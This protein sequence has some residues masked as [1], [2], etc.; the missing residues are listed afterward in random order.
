MA[1]LSIYSMNSGPVF[2]T[3]STLSDHCYFEKRQLFLRSY[4]FSRKKTFSERINR[5][6]VR[7]KR[8]IWVKLKAARKLRRFVWSELR[9]F[10]CRRRRFHRLTIN[11]RFGACNW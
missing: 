2:R 10:Y 7:A 11:Y 4:Q 3:D 5:S 8:V 1:A 9:N 6:F